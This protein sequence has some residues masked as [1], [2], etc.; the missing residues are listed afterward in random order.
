MMDRN[1]DAYYYWVYKLQTNII[2]LVNKIM[3]TF[4]LLIEKVVV[5]YATITR[6]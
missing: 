4:F 5:L 2:Y 3:T 1:I 6:L